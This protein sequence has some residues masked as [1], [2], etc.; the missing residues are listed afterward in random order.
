MESY[1][2]CLSFRDEEI[3]F[4]FFIRLNVHENCWNFHILY[5]EHILV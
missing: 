5:L 3:V 4:L 2:L 1:M